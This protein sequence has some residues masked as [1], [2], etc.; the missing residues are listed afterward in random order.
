MIYFILGFIAGAIVTGFCAVIAF[1]KQG[2]PDLG[3]LS[4]KD[5]SRVFKKEQAEIFEPMPS[6]VEA[7]E[8]LAE[9]K[10]KRGESTNLSDL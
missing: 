10:S 2:S 3:G 4:V 7:L 6:D 9:E 5:I 1:Q 8:A